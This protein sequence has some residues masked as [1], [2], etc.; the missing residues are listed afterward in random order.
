[1]QQDH[2]RDTP[3]EIETPKTEGRF[4]REGPEPGAPDTGT[5]VPDMNRKAEE[6]VI[7]NVTPDEQTD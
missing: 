3:A 7:N 4:R 2:T 1:M 6:S 5:N